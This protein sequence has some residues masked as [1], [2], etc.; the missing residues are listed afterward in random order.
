M[1]IRAERSRRSQ[2]EENDRRSFFPLFEVPLPPTQQW[3]RG[4][5]CKGLAAADENVRARWVTLGDETQMSLA[6]PLLL[7]WW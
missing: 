4:P 5:P 1:R 6:P 2:G 7:S 3:V